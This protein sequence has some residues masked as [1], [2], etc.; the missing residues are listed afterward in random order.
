METTDLYVNLYKAPSNDI[1][2]HRRE[3]YGLWK[4]CDDQTGTW[5]NRVQS[6]IDC[7][8]F[9]PVLSLEYILIDKFVCEL[10]DDEREFVQSVDIWTL[11]QLKEYFQHQEADTVDY[12]VDGNRQTAPLSSVIAV[13]QELVII[14]LNK[15]FLFWPNFGHLR[16]VSIPP[17]DID[18]HS[19]NATEL[20]NKEISFVA[21][22]SD[23]A[24][25][26]NSKAT[27]FHS[28]DEMDP[29][30][31]MKSESAQLEVDTII[32]DTQMEYVSG[33]L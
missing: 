4:R 32:N 18:E 21:I 16:Y 22:K 2:R 5:L 26:N 19:E 15:T 6:H 14:I 3:F 20:A 29:F 8:E 23:V 10:G 11:E 30:V 9:P 27:D 31:E 13:K 24:L 7:C 17:Q 28:I 12:I 25:E 33:N 1:L